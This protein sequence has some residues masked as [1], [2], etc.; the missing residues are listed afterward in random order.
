MTNSVLRQQVAGVML[1]LV[2]LAGCGGPHTARQTAQT[3]VV[4]D[5]FLP[6]A[7]PRTVQ[8]TPPPTRITTL[9]LPWPLTMPDAQQVQ[10]ARGCDVEALVAERYSGV[11]T[12]E[13]AWFCFGL[14]SSLL[15][16]LYPGY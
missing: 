15:D 3:Q 4:T 8:L 1:A 13:A 12:V 5:T 6:T 14:E 16:V 10:E 11:S 9:P 7:T 2:L